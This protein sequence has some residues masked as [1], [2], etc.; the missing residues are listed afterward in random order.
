MSHHQSF[1]SLHSAP[2]PRLA[3]ADLVTGAK[4]A[5]GT[6]PAGR[7]QGAR[8]RAAVRALQSFCADG[9]RGQRL[10]PGQLLVGKHSSVGLGEG[11]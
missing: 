11:N 3:H 5:R 4:L 6:G 7:P 1:P 8:L 2:G 10:L 9:T